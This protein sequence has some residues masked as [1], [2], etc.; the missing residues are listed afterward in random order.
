M[1]EGR[2]EVRIPAV[3]QELSTSEVLVMEF[4]DGGK[5]TDEAGDLSPERRDEL[6]RVC[7]DILFTMVLGERVF[8]GDLHPGNVLLTRDGSVALLDLGL[9]GTLTPTMRDQV[10]DVLVALS[11]GDWNSVAEAFY[12]VAVRTRAVNMREFSAEVADIMDS[13]IA[14]R[15]LSELELGSVLTRL[16]DVGVRF[17]MR[18]PSEFAMMIKAILTVEGLGKTLAP[19]VNPVEIVKPYVAGALRAR[20]APER[21]GQE[22]LRALLTVTRVARELP[23]TLREVISSVEG[24]RLRVGVDLSTARDLSPSLKTALAPVTDAVLAGGLLIAGAMALPHGDTVLLGLPPVSLVLF[25][26]AGLAIIRLLVR[27]K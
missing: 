15:S 21:L 18:V 22:G 2:P 3:I 23:P 13:S 10:V 26:L 7:F 8:H 4:I 24:G 20:Y 17:G 9:V 5:I 14:G 25:S 16:G 6:V 11:Q 12:D 1:F 19:S 27:S